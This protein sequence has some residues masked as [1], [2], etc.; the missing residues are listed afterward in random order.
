MAGARG[1]VSRS[2]MTTKP[3]TQQKRKRHFRERERRDVAHRED[4]LHMQNGASM[5]KSNDVVA[6]NI[7]RWIDRDRDIEGTIG[8]YINKSVYAYIS[9]DVHVYI[10]SDREMELQIERERERYQRVGAMEK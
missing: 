7:T 10:S 8:T 9:I 2:L 5:M 4:I 3:E 1:V 6:A